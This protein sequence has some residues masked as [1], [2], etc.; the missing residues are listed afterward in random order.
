MS[1]DNHVD[2][3]ADLMIPAPWSSKDAGDTLETGDYI[4]AF[5]VGAK[6][7]AEELLDCGKLDDE[8]AKRV[9]AHLKASKFCH[10][11]TMMVYYKPGKDP[12]GVDSQRPEVIWTLESSAGSPCPLFYTYSGSMHFMGQS[13]YCK[14]REDAL[15]LFKKRLSEKTELPITRIGNLGICHRVKTD[16]T[17][18]YWNKLKQELGI[19]E[20]PKHETKQEREHKEML[21]R[22]AAT[23]PVTVIPIRRKCSMPTPWSGVDA[24]EAYECGDYLLVFQKK[25]TT[26][27]NTG[28][29]L[30][31]IPASCF[32][33]L[34]QYSQ[35][36]WLY[37]ISVFYKPG[38]DPSGTDSYAP[39]Y[40]AAICDNG[41]YLS[42]TG[43]GCYG[44][45]LFG[46]YGGTVNVTRRWAFD[47]LLGKVK[48]GLHIPSDSPIQ[49]I[50]TIADA[51]KIKVGRD[52]P[53]PPPLLPDNDFVSFVKTQDRKS[54]T[55]KSQ[56][57]NGPAPANAATNNSTGSG[58]LGMLLLLLSIPVSIFCLVAM[59]VARV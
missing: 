51:Y 14:T 32:D 22:I 43:F 45:T 24:G 35:K 55:W 40:V 18:E 13:C 7:I 37:C 56:R 11:Y 30:E 23:P 49:K 46:G 53:N 54:G 3:S 27:G 59:I 52:M 9:K 28:Y 16:D 31:N 5:Q 47:E 39:H 41:G 15:E 8:Q 58:C 50:G 19:K 10:H 34:K 36:D 25:P 21:A 33:H 29:D 44:D 4:C 6:T 42:G 12:S 1:N 17:C 48:Q 20:Y 38:K 2:F 57:F 26:V